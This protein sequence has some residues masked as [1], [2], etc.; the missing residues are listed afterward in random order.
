MFAAEPRCEL[1]SSK[2]QDGTVNL[3]GANNAS[4]AFTTGTLQ[5]GNGTGTATVQFAS[6]ANLPASSSAIN[7]D[8]GSLAYVGSASATVVNP[9]TLSGAG[10]TVDG[11]GLSGSST[12]T[13]ASEINGPAT[14]TLK[15]T[16]G[17]IDIAGN[18]SA[19]TGS[20]I[21]GGSTKPTTV[22]I[23]A[24]AILPGGGIAIDNGTLRNNTGG[25]TT[26]T[27][28]VALGSAGGTV[29]TNSQTI[30]LIGAISG[31]GGL[32]ITGGG[33]ANLAG[34]ATY[35]G[36]TSIQS[37]TLTIGSGGTITGT[38]ALTI[39]SGA[40]LNLANTAM[41]NGMTINYGSGASPNST[42]QNYI[43]GG[44]ITVPT[45]YAVGYANGADGV[46]SGLGVGQEKIMA[47]LPGDAN[48]DGVVNNTDLALVL[49]NLNQS[50]GGLWTKGDFTG[51][52]TVTNVDLAIVLNNLNRSISTTTTA[53]ATVKYTS[54]P[55]PAALVLLSMAGALSLLQRRRLPKT[56]R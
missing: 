51:S 52:G 25:A 49:N 21:I 15:L 2:L 39:A 30:N 40:T 7:L 36:Q 46:V 9:V 35:T 24:G 5:I 33:I 19:F 43:A 45:G 56:R 3:T 55:E 54:V 32:T 53:S 41:G 38:S 48:L 1:T 17:N 22:S 11:G 34:P 8:G 42:I 16:D 6:A 4:G 47:T 23:D 37:G 12:L 50:S 14:T 20:L 27:N 13:I 18:D 29:D 10:D 26:I 28:A 44:A 31:A